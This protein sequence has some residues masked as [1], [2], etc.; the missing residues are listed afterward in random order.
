M[1]YNFASLMSPKNLKYSAVL[2]DRERIFILFAVPFICSCSVAVIHRYQVMNLRSYRLATPLQIPPCFFFERLLF[3]QRCVQYAD[4]LIGVDTDLSDLF[5]KFCQ[6][7]DFVI[8]RNFYLILPAKMD[9][10]IRRNRGRFFAV[11]VGRKGY[12]AKHHPLRKSMP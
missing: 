3:H 7:E 2:R 6:Q 10:R 8:M 9:N 1:F 4:G 5:F 11:F 12:P